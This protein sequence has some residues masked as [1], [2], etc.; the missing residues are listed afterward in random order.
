MS[1]SIPPFSHASFLPQ[2]RLMQ[3][4]AAAPLAVAVPTAPGQAFS[5]PRYAP[6][7][8][9]IDAASL[10]AAIQE[11]H[12][13]A[14]FDGLVAQLIDVE[15]REDAVIGECDDELIASLQEEFDADPMGPSRSTILHH[16]ITEDIAEFAIQH[17][18]QSDDTVDL[19]L[20]LKIANYYFAIGDADF[21][22]VNAIC[23]D[24]CRN[25]LQAFGMTPYP[26]LDEIRARK[27][28]PKPLWNAQGGVNV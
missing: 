12:R 24:A 18:K 8:S 16:R 19:A 27:P 17:G 10:T 15:V 21:G 25:A 7:F 4:M 6:K 2:R 23:P 5:H 3:V 22:E 11:D 9:P 1:R 28:E 14:E 20:Q 13:F 26:T